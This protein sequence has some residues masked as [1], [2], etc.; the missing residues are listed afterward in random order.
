VNK[1]NGSSKLFLTTFS[2]G[3]RNLHIHNV[4]QCYSKYVAIYK[5]ILSNESDFS[6]SWVVS[7]GLCI[8]SFIAAIFPKTPL[9]L[10]VNRKETSIIFRILS[11]QRIFGVGWL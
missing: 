2:L 8:S 3:N 10:K 5:V 7:A 1:I 11:F 9:N 6:I 4:R